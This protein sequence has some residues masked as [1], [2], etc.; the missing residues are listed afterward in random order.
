MFS[1]PA[2][3]GARIYALNIKCFE[4]RNWFHGWIFSMNTFPFSVFGW[5]VRS[6]ASESEILE[7]LEITIIWSRCSFAVWH[8]ALPLHSLLMSNAICSGQL[9]ARYC[10]SLILE[11]RVPQHC[12]VVVCTAWD[13]YGVLL[14]YIFHCIVYIPVY[15]RVCCCVIFSNTLNIYPSV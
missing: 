13:E 14:C 9:Y 3:S 4:E 1:H 5:A 6:P 8:Y 15:S 11:Q 7:I 12:N 10:S 2:L